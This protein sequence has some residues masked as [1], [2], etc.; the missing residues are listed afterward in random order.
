MPTLPLTCWILPLLSFLGTG[1]ASGSAERVACAGD[2]IAFEREGA[3]DL[4]DA[5]LSSCDWR[6]IRAAYERARHAVAKIPGGH[7][8]R[9]PHQRWSSLFDGRGVTVES[10]CGGWSWG[11]ELESYGYADGMPHAPSGPA[12]VLVDGEQ[13]I[14][15]WGDSVEEWYRNGRAG[16]EH[17]FTVERPLGDD[18][19]GG[20]G[21]LRF[22]LGVRGELE[23]RVEEG[24]LG[25][26][27]AD[28]KGAEVLA[29]RGLYAFDADGVELDARLKLRGS[30]LTVEVETCG[31]KYPITIDPTVSA[32]YL[33]AAEPGAGDLFGGAVDV[34]GDIVVVGAPW[35]G[36]A[37]TGVNGDQTDD[38]APA[39]GAAYVFVRQGAGW[40]QEAYLKASNTDPSDYFGESVAVSGNT[41]VVGARGES[42]QGRG[43]GAPQG[44]NLSPD[45]GAAYVFVR[46][47][48]SGSWSQQA[49]LK[50]SNADPGDHFG[51][52]VDLH[53]DTVLVGALGEDSN[54][55]GV[56]G[57]QSDNSL[58]VAGAAYVFVRSGGVWT[59]Q[60]YLKASNPDP[61]DGFGMSVAVFGDRVAIGA[62]GESGSSSG[63]NGPQVDN[64]MSR[65]GACYVFKRTAGIWSQEAYVKASNPN[66]VAG[67]G[68]SVALSGDALVVGVP[69]EANAASGVG[70]DQ[71]DWS[72]WGTGAAYVFRHDGATWHQEEY[73][74][75]ANAGFDDRF[76]RSVAISG[77]LI[78]VGAPQEDGAGAGLGGDSSLDSV[79]NSGA[80]Y[81]FQK[82]AGGWA[83][84]AYIK[85]SNPAPADQFGYAVGLTESDVIVGAVYED[86]GLLSDPLDNSTPSSG[87]A[88][89]YQT[90]DAFPWSVYCSG[91]GSGMPCPCGNPG[92]AGEGCANSTGTGASLTASGAALVSDDSLVLTVGGTVPGQPGIFFQGDNEVNGGLGVPFGDGLR[93]AGGS[94]VRLRVVVGDVGGVA[95]STGV[96]VSVRG[97]VSG[98][99]TK[100]YQWWYRDPSGSPCGSGFGLSNGVEVFWGM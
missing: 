88:Y 21:M 93:C 45:S 78:L 9:S 33:K 68:F 87:A 17:G 90:E 4:S 69:W 30:S 25:V 1:D 61:G 52:A 72:A 71:S 29:Y 58:I 8:A 6:G 60:A 63:V 70:A 100:R 22:S 49:F 50:S 3:A 12:E 43:V 23:G 84:V 98:G 38:S 81:L 40:V 13:V 53:G 54:S 76:G 97:G 44:N 18:G 94:V 99:E 31:A 32:A 26:S 56:N 77:D 74:K 19:V 85:S 83:Q 47:A 2:G 62:R 24:A 35:E 89:V 51:L 41:I 16:L 73:L 65:S 42:S 34:S 66:P 55:A 7:R 95:S 10:D 37:S 67:F 20:E 28:E 48:G 15:R 91:D 59:Q 36:S 96:Q 11:L 14:Y 5:G 80:S 82:G 57:V 39:S 86:S 27:F 92:G 79:S 46:Q 64:A 75:A